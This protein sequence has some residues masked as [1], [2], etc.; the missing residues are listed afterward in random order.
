MTVDSFRGTTKKSIA[1][2]SDVLWAKRLLPYVFLLPYFG[3]FVLFFLWPILWAP[4]MSLHE[5]GYTGSTL[6]GIKQYAEL[7]TDDR[8]YTVSANT[9]IIT[10]ISIPIQIVGGLAAALVLNSA[11]VRAKKVLRAAYIL[12]SVLSLTVLS[13]LF[14]IFLSTDGMINYFLDGV[15]GHTVGWL[16]DPLIAKVSVAGVYSWRQIGISF[17]IFFSGLQGIPNQLYKAAKIDGA[18]KLQ[19]FR[20]I[21]L[22]QLRPITILV[23]VLTTTY[24]VRLFDVPFVLTDGGP[25]NASQ[26]IVQ[27]MYILAFEELALGKASALG[28]IITIGLGAVLIVQY[29]IGRSHNE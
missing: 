7:L 2:L 13:I 12:P 14:T 27:L 22:P 6:V 21:T 19:Q 8:F 4:W 23:V 11:V 18:G 3:V 26:T 20:Y 5:Y 24:S 16:N 1:A 10:I 29:S 15:F 28:V 25:G 17:L 9:A